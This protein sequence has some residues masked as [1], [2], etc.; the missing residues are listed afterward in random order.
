[1]SGHYRAKAS[2]TAAACRERRARLA[3]ELK[4]R[5]TAIAARIESRVYLP[6]MAHIRLVHDVDRSTLTSRALN[7][8]TLSGV[9]RSTPKNGQN[10]GPIYWVAPDL[11]LS[12]PPN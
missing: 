10:A 11:Q 8:M 5:P 7:A 4:E 9:T 2:G 1:M 12:A 3:D 6:I